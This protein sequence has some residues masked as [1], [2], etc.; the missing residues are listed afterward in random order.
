MR[1]ILIG[2]FCLLL[3]ASWNLKAFAFPPGYAVSMKCS[4]EK[5]TRRAGYS[6][7]L[8]FKRSKILRNT[9]EYSGVLTKR[10]RSG[11]LLVRYRLFGTWRIG[12]TL[13]GSGVVEVLRRKDELKGLLAVGGQ[14]KGADRY[15][16][17][18][19]SFNLGFYKAD[20]QRASLSL[21]CPFREVKFPA[22]TPTPKPVL[23][24][25]SWA[26]TW[27]CPHPQGAGVMTLTGQG[28]ESTMRVDF[29]TA[30]YGPAYDIS[31]IDAASLYSASGTYIY[32][33]N[34]PGRT[35]WPGTFSLSIDGE[36]IQLMR[37]DGSSS[38]SGVY[39]C[40]RRGV[41]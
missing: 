39:Y 27:D 15:I 12:G 6:V 18:G 17:E 19:D 14:F 10:D 1:N 4:V 34:Y 22:P 38:W 13:L 20:D 9:F 23:T 5:Q 2:S 7:R 8:N 3:L 41:S 35:T 21:R 30:A 31:A 28:E 25:D 37:N 11:R 16:D 40:L 29:P 36:T 33:N 24:T 32:H 26:G